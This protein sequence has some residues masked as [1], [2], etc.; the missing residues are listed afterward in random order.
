MESSENSE[1]GCTPGWDM[2]RPTAGKGKE[3]QYMSLSYILLKIS[4][5]MVLTSVSVTDT[6]VLSN[7]SVS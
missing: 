1:G 4:P 7:R 2:E 6:E 3:G 5:L